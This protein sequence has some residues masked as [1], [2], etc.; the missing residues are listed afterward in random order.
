[1]TQLVNIIAVLTLLLSLVALGLWLVVLAAE[2]RS[3]E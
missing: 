1:V 3:G 2:I